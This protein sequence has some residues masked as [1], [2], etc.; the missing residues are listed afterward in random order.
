MFLFSK[1]QKNKKTQEL[2]SLNSRSDYLTGFT[3]IELIVALGIFSLI[4]VALVGLFV[5]SLR[6][7]RKALNVQL[8]QD[9]ARL[10]M[11]TMVRELRDSLSVNF[12][13]DQAINL[14][15]R[16]GAPI[17]YS[18][19]ACNSNPAMNCIRRTTNDLATDSITDLGSENVNVANLKFFG[20]NS[21]ALSNQPRITIFFTMESGM[22]QYQASINL[23]TTV[24]LRNVRL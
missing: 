21:G 18:W 19:E 22:S 8:V 6:S 20:V 15:D 23:Q 2:V 7:E 1:R 4:S 16:T 13:T 24:S 9:N 17:S 12:I 3:L 10:V 14:I 5:S 11:E